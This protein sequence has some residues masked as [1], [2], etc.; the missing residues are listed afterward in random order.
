[1]IANPHIRYC[2]ITS[3]KGSR[4]QRCGV[5]VQASAFSRSV[6]LGSE[7]EPG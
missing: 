7:S 2:A 3:G 1:M 6:T 5:S 4:G